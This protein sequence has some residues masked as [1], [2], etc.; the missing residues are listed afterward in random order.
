VRGLYLPVGLSFPQPLLNVAGEFEKEV[1]QG[2][3]RRFLPIPTGF[4]DLDEALSGGMYPGQLVILGGKPNVGK[5]VLAL[6]LA[7]NFALGGAQALMV[8]YEH[9]E[10]HLFQRLLAMESF[11]QGGGLTLPQIREIM[12]ECAALGYRQVLEEILKRFP[13]NRKALETILSYM[14]RLYLSRGHPLKTS[15]EVLETYVKYVRQENPGEQVVLIVDYL[16]K[17]PL[18]PGE[19]LQVEKVAAKLKDL[20]LA[21]EVAVVAVSALDAAGV[22]D[23]RPGMAD[24]WGGSL[25]KYEPDTVIMLHISGLKG[26]WAEVEW[27]IEKNRTG[28]AGVILRRKLRG[29]HFCFEI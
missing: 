21:E 8:C 28:P 7:R 29:K 26:E 19:E 3:I 13:E 6:Q 12:L 23:S 20:A 11:L 15:T 22:K 2:G 17:V 27:V 5:T 9:S 18:G 16:Q 4:A 14:G 1:T 25:V 10:T 24:L